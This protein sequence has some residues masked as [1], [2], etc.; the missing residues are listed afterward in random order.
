M[1]KSV[2]FSFYNEWTKQDEWHGNPSLGLESWAK[3]FK[4]PHNGRLTPVYVFGEP[5]SKDL[6][7]SFCVS[8]GANSDYSYSG[9][10]FPEKYDFPEFMAQVDILYNQG[11]LFR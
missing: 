6:D 3:H 9:C 5:N 11:R 10:F 7:L 8:A 1:T 4:N 2:K